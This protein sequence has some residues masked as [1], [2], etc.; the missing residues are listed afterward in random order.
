MKTTN[1]APHTTGIFVRMTDEQYAAIAKMAKRDGQTTE[2]W[3]NGAAGDVIGMIANVAQELDP[4]TAGQVLGVSNYT[5]I[6]YFHDGKFPNAFQLTDRTI[7]IPRSDV[8]KLKASRTVT[9]S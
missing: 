9:R 2:E 7:R 3:F 6:R 1:P 4:K 8:E 5:I